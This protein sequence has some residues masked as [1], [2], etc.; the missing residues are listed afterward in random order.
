M[1]D[2]NLDGF[3]YGAKAIGREADI[4]ERDKETDEIILDEHGRPKVDVRKAHY[5]LEQ[6][7]IDADKFGRIWRSTPR[8]IKQLT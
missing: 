5:A 6:G 3:V 4:Y 8:R 7:Y 2:K 1:S